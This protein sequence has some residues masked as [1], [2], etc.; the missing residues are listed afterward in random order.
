[1]IVAEESDKTTIIKGVLTWLNGQPF[2]NVLILLLIAVIAWAVYD[3]QHNIIPAERKAIED[4]VERVEERQS[5]EIDRICESF[6]KAL[7]RTARPL[8]ASHQQGE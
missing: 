4:M 2:N 7:D 8:A 1:L 6:D 5:K 3:A